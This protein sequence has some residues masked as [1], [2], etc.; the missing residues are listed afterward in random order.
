MPPIHRPNLPRIITYYQ[1]HHDASGQLISA[2]PL[3]TAKGIELT[4][5]IVGAIHLNDDPNGMT[6]N[7]HHPDHERFTSLWA[8]LRILQASGVKVLGMLGGAAKGSYERL[9]QDRLTFERYY[10]PLRDMVRR[11]GLDGL[12]L[13]VEEP[14]SLAGIIR[15][16]DRLRADFGRDFILTLAPVAAALL[17]PMRNLS[18][19]DYEALEVMRGSEIAWYNTQFY[20]GWGD[21]SNPLMYEMIVARGWPANKVVVGMVTNPENGAGHVPWESLSTVIPLLVGRHPNF[22]GVSGWEYFNSLPGGREKPWEWAECM[23]GLLRG[24]KPIPPTALH[25]WAD[26]ASHALV[27]IDPD[28]QGDGAAP[29]PCEFEYHTD[30]DTDVD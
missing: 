5:L 13:D 15:L 25:Q 24:E 8:E 9:D 7:D 14:M 4:H 22:A 12:D 6:L 18:G 20:C 3:V 2:L 16:I 30:T 26:R 23:T 27:D 11:R 19:F 21:C 28:S 10:V 1:T 29:V 17:D